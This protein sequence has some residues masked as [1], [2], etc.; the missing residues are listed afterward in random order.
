M[1]WRRSRMSGSDGPADH[2]PHVRE[3][4]AAVAG[5]L[6][7]RV[8]VRH[9][10]VV[11]HIHLG[12]RGPRGAIGDLGSVEARAR[13]RVV[14]EGFPAGESA[15]AQLERL[16]RIDR[17]ERLPIDRLPELGLDL[18]GST[19]RRAPR[20]L[21]R[22]V[23]HDLDAHVSIDHDPEPTPTPR[24]P[25]RPPVTRGE[26]RTRHRSRRRPAPHTP[27]EPTRCRTTEA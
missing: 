27:S 9:D 1:C 19:Q 6:A 2:A 10:D 23:F 15:P 25:R 22:S 5:V 24:G 20:H 16:R 13:T 12:S 11:A 4:V 7:E 17:R 18:G 21:V 14:A 3:P 26:R 8:I